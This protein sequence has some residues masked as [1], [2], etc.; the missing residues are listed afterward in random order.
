MNSYYHARVSAK[1]FG[2]VPEDYQPIHDFIDSSKSSVADVRHRAMLHSAWGI[3]LTEKVFGHTIPNSKGDQVPVR[4]IAEEHILEDLGFIPSMEH[5]LKNMR[6]ETWMSGTRKR[7]VRP[8][9]IKL[10]EKSDE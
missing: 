5:W 8:T 2:G 9:V 3:F 4:L 10:E 6:I 7:K 1:K